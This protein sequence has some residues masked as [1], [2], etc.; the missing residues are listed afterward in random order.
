VVKIRKGQ[1]NPSGPRASTPLKISGCEAKKRYAESLTD[2][3]RAGLLAARASEAEA[4][5]GTGRDRRTR[6]TDWL[7]PGP[8]QW[9]ADRERLG[10]LEPVVGAIRRDL[11][12]ASYS[13][14][15]VR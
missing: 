6:T 14:S 4:E 11:L 3:R 12:T 8:G 9:S 2:S 5:A 15:K 13:A 10:I 1:R 7:D